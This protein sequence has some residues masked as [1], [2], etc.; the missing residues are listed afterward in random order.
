MSNP[1]AGNSPLKSTRHTFSWLPLGL[2]LM[3][4]VALYAQALYFEFVY[5]DLGQIVSNPQIKSWTRALWY[6]RTH[7]WAQVSRRAMYYRPVYMLWLTA[8]FKL[9]GLNPFYWHLAVI[10]LHLV[11]CVLVY[12]LVFRLAKD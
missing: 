3:C 1:A 6:F 11:C 8:N 7:V 12:L 9:F 2:A 10:G 5:D 4:T